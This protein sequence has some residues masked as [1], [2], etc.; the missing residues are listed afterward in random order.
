[1]TLYPDGCRGRSSHRRRPLGPRVRA[2]LWRSNLVDR[3]SSGSDANII[4]KSN[5]NSRSF[6]GYWRVNSK[7]SFPLLFAFLRN[8]HEFRNHLYKAKNVQGWNICFFLPSCHLIHFKGPQTGKL[9][10]LAK[11]NTSIPVS[12]FGHMQ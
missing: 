6:S 11:N 7:Y 8:S 4:R 2:G 9:R 5:S 10:I 1:M 12:N 3:V